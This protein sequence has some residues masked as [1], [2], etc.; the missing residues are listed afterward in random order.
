[1]RHHYIVGIGIQ[2]ARCSNPGKPYLD[3][4]IYVPHN[5]IKDLELAKAAAKN[6]LYPTT[7]EE[8][9]KVFGISNIAASFFGASIRCH[10]H[11]L[12]TCHFTSDVKLNR[13]WF[14]TYVQYTPFEDLKKAEI[15]RQKEVEDDLSKLFRE[16]SGRKQKKG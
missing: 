5:K 8:A 15:K 13:Q 11:Q 14:N 12:I 16:D 2:E 9:N 1:M 7:S 4:Y 3:F 6:K 10:V